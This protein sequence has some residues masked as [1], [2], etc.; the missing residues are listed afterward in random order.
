M[1][2]NVINSKFFVHEGIEQFLIMLYWCFITGDYIL[3]NIKVVDQFCKHLN[4]QC[5]KIKY[6]V[7]GKG[8]E[9]ASTPKH[10]ADTPKKSKMASPT[11]TKMESP[12]KTKAASPVKINGT[13]KKNTPAVK[14]ETPTRRSA[15]L[16]Q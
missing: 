9:D 10:K 14:V 6:T 1:A 11:K 13:P 15:R 3:W 4:I 5:F 2:S 8:T 7:D 16:N 12:V